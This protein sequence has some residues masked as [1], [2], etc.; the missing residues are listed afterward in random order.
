MGENPG[1]GSYIHDGVD[2][3]TIAGSTKIDPKVNIPA[4]AISSMLKHGLNTISSSG[5]GAFFRH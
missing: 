1:P 5:T 4:P 2:K 3:S